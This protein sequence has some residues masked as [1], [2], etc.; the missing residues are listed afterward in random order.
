MTHRSDLRLESSSRVLLVKPSGDFPP[1]EESDEY[2]GSVDWDAEWKKVVADEGKLSG[3]ERP[4]K[5]FYKSEA[6]IAAIKA[7][8]KAA[9]KVGNVGSSVSN[10]MP[11]MGSLSGD[12]KVR[13]CQV[14]SEASLLLH[15]V[16]AHCALLS[17][18][19][20]RSSPS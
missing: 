1:E 17:S 14:N 7:A 20:S 16:V 5:D 3:A 18:F 6:E 4:G 9:E 2:T 10:A 13:F 11:D 15:H 19:G 12:W 8:N